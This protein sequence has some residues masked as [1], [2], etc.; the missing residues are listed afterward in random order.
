MTEILKKKGFFKRMCFFKDIHFFKKGFK[1]GFKNIFQR[2][3]IFQQNALKDVFKGT[4]I[5]IN[6]FQRTCT[7][8][9]ADL[10]IYLF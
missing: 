9:D 2:I 1:E 8:K 4:W 3:W 5:F 6:F 10:F 7:S